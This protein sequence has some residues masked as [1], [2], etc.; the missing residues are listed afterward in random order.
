MTLPVAPEAVATAAN[1][2]HQTI[3]SS[4]FPR[5][6]ECRLTRPSDVVGSDHQLTFAGKLPS[7]GFP[8][9]VFLVGVEVHPTRA[10]EQVFDVLG[11]GF[12]RKLCAF[13]STDIR[14]STSSLSRC[15]RHNHQ[16]RADAQGEEDIEGYLWHGSYTHKPGNGSEQDQLSNGGPCRQG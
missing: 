13:S 3:S 11:G 5:V 15:R 16:G 14:G 8:S 12:C 2:Y 1:T 7:L 6:R 10:N 9:G 4:N